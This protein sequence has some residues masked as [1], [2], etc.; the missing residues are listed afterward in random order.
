M[1][2]ESERRR[3]ERLLAERG[4][5]FT[6]V[7]LDW[8]ML[9]LGFAMLALGVVQESPR[10]LLV[11]AAAGAFLVGVGLTRLFLAK[12]LALLARL[13]AEHERGREPAPGA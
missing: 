10:D 11:L 3:C 12:D 4:N 13:Y 6:R 1:I 7:G 9:V 8:V 2:V 5:R